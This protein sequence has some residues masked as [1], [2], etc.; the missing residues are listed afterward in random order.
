MTDGELG[1]VVEEMFAPTADAAQAAGVLVALRLVGEG[2]RELVAFARGLRERMRRVDAPV[3]AVD[4]CGTGG[5]GAGTFNVSTAAALV[6]ASVGVPVAKHGNR[7]VSGRVGSA[8]VLEAL[9]VRVELTPEQLADCLRSTSIAFLHAPALH[10]AMAAIAPVRRAL[11]IRT[12]FNLVGPLANPAGVRRQVVGVPATRWLRPMAEALLQLGSE[13]AWVVHGYG[14]LDEL[15][16]GGPSSV[17]EVSGGEIRAFSVDPADLG[18]ARSPLRTLAVG[19]VEESA[20]RIRGV[21]RGEAG[22]SRDVVCLNAAATLLVAG[23]VSDLGSGLETAREAIDSGQA[24]RVLE[25]LAEVTRVEAG[26]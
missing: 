11:G 8:D 19:S 9:G 5:D 3:G 18:I 14:G 13:R 20:V 17:H 24:L 26:S 12:I 2:P 1:H 6:V 16:I 4:T 7:A 10:P 15:S 22:P 23:R 25:R 21:L